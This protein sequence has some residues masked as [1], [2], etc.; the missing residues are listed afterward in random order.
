M[1]GL[2]ILYWRLLKH[3]Y[4]WVQQWCNIIPLHWVHLAVRGCQMKLS[5]PNINY[6]FFIH[7][8]KCC[9]QENDRNHVGHWI[10]YEFYVD[11]SSIIYPVIVNP[12][13]KKPQDKSCWFS[14]WLQVIIKIIAPIIRWLSYVCQ[15][16]LG[17]KLG[18][19]CLEYGLQERGWRV[20]LILDFIG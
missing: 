10:T 15:G 4:D 13:L 17:S 11:L 20:C 9:K 12:I 2:N 5:R 6:I 1:F 7:L 3:K 14:S 16:T 19:Q 8:H 18:A